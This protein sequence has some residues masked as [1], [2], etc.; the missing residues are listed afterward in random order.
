MSGITVQQMADRV[1]ALME[2][3]LR[4]KGAGLS[5]KLR[6]GGRSLP[7]RFRSNAAYLA[8]ASAKA[9]VPRLVLQLDHQRIAAS[10]DACMKHLSPIGVGQRRRAYLFHLLVSAALAVFAAG[11]MVIGVMVWRGLI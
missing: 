7:R 11:A 5:Q 1:A 10:Y 8:E 3:R 6:R 2:D 4:I 9:A